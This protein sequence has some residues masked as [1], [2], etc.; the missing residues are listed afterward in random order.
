MKI[1]RYYIFT[2]CM[3]S[4]TVIPAFSDCACKENDTNKEIYK[5]S[6][7]T[8][9]FLITVGNVFCFTNVRPFIDLC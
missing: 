6:C 4:F 1:G 9:R 7:L 5:T 2:S 3:L 8:I